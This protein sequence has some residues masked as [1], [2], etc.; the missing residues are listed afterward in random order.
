VY[1]NEQ[2]HVRCIMSK[3]CIKSTDCTGIYQDIIK[4]SGH[5]SRIVIII[6]VKYQHVRCQVITR[7]MSGNIK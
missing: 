3:G 6:R 5:H 4:M 2:E 7:Q 1:E